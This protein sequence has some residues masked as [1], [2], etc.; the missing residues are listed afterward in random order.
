M[1]AWHGRLQRAESPKL[2]PGTIR[3][4]T[5]RTIS[6][7]RIA[8]CLPL[9]SGAAIGCFASHDGSEGAVGH[10]AGLIQRFIFENG[11]D[12]IAVLVDVAVVLFNRFGSPD[13]AVF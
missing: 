9:H 8:H 6:E 10:L 11:L 1:L 2:H 4:Q 5:L 3:V 7:I 12:E 13:L